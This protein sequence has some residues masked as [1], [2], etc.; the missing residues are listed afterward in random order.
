L[1]KLQNSNIH[2]YIIEEIRRKI[3]EMKECEW[4]VTL[5]WV[6]A[7][8]GVMGNELADTLAKRAAT[9]K[10]IPES[11]NKIPKSVVMK[12]LEE[13][14]VKKWQ[15]KWTETTKGRTTTEYFP[16]VSERLK[17]KLQLTQNFTAIVSGHGK[18]RDKLHRFKIIEQ[19]TC[20]CGKGDQTADHIIYACVRL[21]EE[22]D[23]LKKTAI[24]TNK[25]PI[26]KRDLIR[27]HYN[28]FTNFIKYI[29]FDKLNVE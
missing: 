5:C 15:R 16:D 20:P 9:N 25:W 14:S 21:T 26:N 29:H 27:R 17:M 12:D 2:T 8:A 6:R 18:T 19:P 23:R 22:R 3:T 28:P 10:N 11:Y 4:K 13:E 7:Q 24:G 1:G